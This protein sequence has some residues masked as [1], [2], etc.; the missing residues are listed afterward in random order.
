MDQD[1]IQKIAA[2]IVR[3][4]PTYWWTLL[5]IQVILTLL[6]AGLGA[7]FGEYLKTRGKNLATRADLQSLKDQLRANTELVETI[8]AEVAH[9]DWSKREWANLRR[10]KLEELLTKALDCREFLDRL[11]TASFE[12][13]VT[14]YRNPI[15]DAETIADLYFPE[16][17]AQVNDLLVRHQ[18]LYQAC[19]ALSLD[20]LKAGTNDTLRIAAGKTYHAVLDSEYQHYLT[21]AATLTA[22][23]RDLVREIMSVD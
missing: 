1:T 22:A 17:A 3:H 10:I 13:R 20:T 23:A 2:E 16:L 8:R 9:K 4:L 11:Q 5:I 7:F 6:A 21:S 19:I 18:R 12:G 14:D 15:Y